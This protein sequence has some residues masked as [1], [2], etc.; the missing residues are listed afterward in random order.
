MIIRTFLTLLALALTAPQQAFAERT[1]PQSEAQIHLSFAPIVKKIAPAVVNIYTKR[2]VKVVTRSPF[3]NDPFFSMFMNQNMFGGQM[4]ERVESALGSG[5]IVRPEGTVITNSHVIKDASEITVVLNDGREFEAELI[6]QDDAADLALLQIKND[7]LVNLPYAPL[8]PSE[9]LEIGDLVLAIGNPFGVGQTVTSGIVSAQ[10]R[11]TLNINDYNFFIQTDAAINPGN[12]GGALVTLDGKVVGINTAI[13]S[14]NGGSLGIGFAIPSEMVESILA[15]ADQGLKGVNEIK[16]PW[17]GVTAQMM[18]SDIAQSLNLTTPHGVLIAD[19]HPLSPLRSAKIKSGDVIVKMNGRAIKDPSEMKFRMATVPLGK[20]ANLTVLRAGK[21]FTT[22]VKAIPAPDQ[23][24]R[25]QTIL[26]GNHPFNGATV[27]NLN[28]AVISELGLH[29]G[30]QAL[31]GVVI[32]DI[33]PQSPANR[34][35]KKGD[36]IL[37]LN[38]IAITTVSDL[39]KAIH[40]GITNQQGWN[41]ILSSNGQNRQIILR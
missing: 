12:S 3:F 39:N 38:G 35:S 18:T 41:I 6:L 21:E 20:T 8:K 16:R 30:G 40:A 10:G 25:E 36:L 33:S 17:M 1:I 5:V 34:V 32:M 24:D 22:D 11:S 37:S 27:A 2:K 13:Y 14:R 4:K 9:S 28:P 7:E 26:K 19:L 15:A 29:E 31:K 23:P